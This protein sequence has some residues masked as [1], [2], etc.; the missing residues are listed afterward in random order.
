M[1]ICLVGDY[2]GTSDEGMKNVSQTFKKTLSVVHEVLT[3]GIRDMVNPF[4]ILK[5]R[6]HT[7]QIIHYFHGPTIRSLI[8][9]KL[10][11]LLV[12]ANVKVVVSA[13]KPYFPKTVNC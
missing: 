10:V 3:F 8:I 5:I 4:N 9:L 7:P 11:K 12:R 13:T 6:K 2:S 1:K